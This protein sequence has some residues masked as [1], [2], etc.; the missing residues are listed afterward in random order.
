M[1]NVEIEGKY[2]CT[3]LCVC[4]RRLKYV[5]CVSGAADRDARAALRQS[6]RTFTGALLGRFGPEPRRWPWDHGLFGT[7]LCDFHLNPSAFSCSSPAVT[8]RA[9]G[10]LG[11]GGAGGCSMTR[12]GFA[13][14]LPSAELQKQP[15]TP[16]SLLLPG[17]PKYH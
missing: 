1:E 13:R 3:G 14:V 9:D 15:V 2:A 5:R 4:L 8:C 16:P 17:P 11:A 6:P 12:S 7:C 10:G